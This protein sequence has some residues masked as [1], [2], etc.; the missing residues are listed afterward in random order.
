MEVELAIN[1]KEFREMLAVLR[2]PPGWIKTPAAA[3]MRKEFK[4]FM[5]IARRFH[6]SGGA[7]APGDVGRIGQS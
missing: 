4:L 6:F 3:A 1:E 5:E 7:A 2:L